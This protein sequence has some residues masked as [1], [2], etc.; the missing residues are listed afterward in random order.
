MM[1]L[2]HDYMAARRDG[3]SFIEAVKYACNPTPAR[4]LHYDMALR[5]GAPY[6]PR[7]KYNPGDLP[8]ASLA[9]QALAAGLIKEVG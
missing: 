1:Q 9:S 8:Q 5:L 2:F 7:Q 3:D 6:G 4:I